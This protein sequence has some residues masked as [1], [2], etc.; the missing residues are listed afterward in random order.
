MQ[1]FDSE[2]FL[3]FLSSLNFPLV[4]IFSVHY[5]MMEVQFVCHQN[6]IFREEILMISSFKSCSAIIYI[7]Q[8][9]KSKITLACHKNLIQKLWTYSHAHKSFTKSKFHCV[10]IYALDSFI[11]NL[12]EFVTVGEKR[13]QKSCSFRITCALPQ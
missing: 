12:I 11:R 6:H 10:N 8:N 4:S 5:K 3:P 13:T 9:F 7:G 2:R 1:K